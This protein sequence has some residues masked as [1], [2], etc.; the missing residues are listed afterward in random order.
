MR[1]L[2]VQGAMAARAERV[3]ERLAPVPVHARRKWR[4]AAIRLTC[5]LASAAVVSPSAGQQEVG[6]APSDTGAAS[7]PERLA[8]TVLDR[9]ANGGMEAFQAVFPFEPELKAQVLQWGV[10]LRSAPP[11]VVRHGD[12]HALVVLGAWPAIGNSG[13]EMAVGR[14]FSGL[15][16]AAR[17]DNGWRLTEAIPAD[18]GNRVLRHALHVGL[19][20]GRGLDVVDTLQVEVRGE[21]GFGLRLNR[22]ADLR[23]VSLD[24]RPLDPVFRGG[25]LWLDLP[26]IGSAEL[27][28]AYHLPVAADSLGSPNSGRFAD[29]HGH[30]RD[31]YFWHPFFDF[32]NANDRATFEVTVRAPERYRVITTLPQQH[33]VRDG[34]RT[35]RGRSIQPTFAL[36]LLYDTL[37]PVVSRFGDVT[38][39]VYLPADSDPS[40]DSVL[41][42][43]EATYDI[44]AGRFGFPA[45]SYLAIALTP[46]RGG[47]GWNFR[48]NHLIAG[49][50]LPGLIDRAGPFPRAW[51]GHE[52]AHGWTIP[53]GPAA[54]FLSEGWANY[55]ESLLIGAKYGPAAEADF[56]E[57]QRTY[58][59]RSDLEGRARLSYDPHNSGVSYSKGSW[60][61]RMLRDHVGQPA[62][63]HGMRD[64]MTIPPDQDTG[65]EAF[66]DAM[67]AASGRDVRAFLNPW[68]EG[69]VIPD[70]QARIEEGRVIVEQ[71]QESLFWLDL[72]LE[73]VTDHD[74]IRRPLALRGR[75]AVLPTDG[76]GQVRDVLIDPDHLLLIRRHRGDNVRFALDAPEASE[77]L[78]NA[79]FLAS[80]LPASQDADGVWTVD[81][82]LSA[83]TYGYWWTVDGRYRQPEG[84]GRLVVEPRAL[85][86]EEAR[87]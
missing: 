48:S 2:G 60:V 34:I 79:T 35:T 46:L 37:Q 56:W 71:R 31:Q 29:Q 20:P 33:H 68:I 1:R 38:V 36:G 30:L 76:I 85:V 50:A 67:A 8:Q 16:R 21:D 39:E 42:A 41:A 53:S 4:L 84:G 5:A 22:T 47:G 27:V 40:A 45:S 25:Y 6:T 52:V 74:T 82:P 19:D 86:G 15:Y 77:V 58:Y 72:T 9:L 32:G 55:A 75:T 17:D 3:T 57:S 83:G 18:A 61:L 62:F 87:P 66:A 51:L 73:L 14:A 43:V 54:N 70:L 65:V 13:D 11:A 69:T 49:G 28:V 64:Y 44:L 63:D 24:G 10:E 78:L 81:V 12:D 80:G 23:D 26:P 59:Q 7:T